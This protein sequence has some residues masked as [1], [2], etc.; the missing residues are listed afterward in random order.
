MIISNISGKNH[1]S[2]LKSLASNSD[3]LVFSSPFLFL[4]FEEFFEEII[5]DKITKLT[6]ITT[7]HPNIQD[8]IN[9][10]VSFVSFVGPA[11]SRDLLLSSV[12]SL[13][14]R[15]SSRPSVPSWRT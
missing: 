5:S 11:S 13:S 9:K 7:L 4:D 6:L 15:V 3:E 10:S 1:L 12:D 2:I 14:D 8:L